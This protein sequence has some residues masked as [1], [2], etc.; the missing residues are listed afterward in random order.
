[1]VEKCIKFTLSNSLFTLEIERKIIHDTKMKKKTVVITIYILKAFIINSILL[2]YIFLSSLESNKVTEIFQ[3]ST[4][5]HKLT[6]L[7]TTMIM[8]I[9]IMMIIMVITKPNHYLINLLLQHINF[10]SVSPY[11][12]VT[13]KNLP[14]A[15]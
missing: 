14:N 1:M 4:K 12:C 8:K 5:F 13:I 2:S 15:K 10:L 11:H 9:M 7:M 6:I 3:K